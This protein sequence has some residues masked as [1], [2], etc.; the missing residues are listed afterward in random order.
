MINSKVMEFLT[1]AQQQAYKHKTLWY[2]FHGATWKDMEWITR[3]KY[4]GESL[5]I[6]NSIDV[7][8]TGLMYREPEE[9]IYMD[10]TSAFPV[11]PDFDFNRTLDSFR[12]AMSYAVS[13]GTC[14]VFLVYGDHITHESDGI[15]IRCRSFGG[16][17]ID[18]VRF[19]TQEELEKGGMRYE[20]E[21]D[22]L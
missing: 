22:L 18:T 12:K 16:S 14:R 9:V 21:S 6:Y 11:F 8:A 19:F 7:Q 13:Y 5:R 4:R 15:S 3:Y 20:K 1:Y 17:Y 2:G 10:G